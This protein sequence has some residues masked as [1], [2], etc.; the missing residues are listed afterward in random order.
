M[1]NRGRSG[2]RSALFAL[3]VLSA[4][5]AVAAADVGVPGVSAAAVVEP[6]NG[7]TIA[8]TDAPAASDDDAR[9]DM[10]VEVGIRNHVDPGEAMLVRVGVDASSLFDGQVRVRVSSVAPTTVDV[11]VPGG[12]TKTVLL[13]APGSVD[14][15][16]LVVELVE[17]GSIVE[18]ERVTIEGASD[19]EL[20]GVLPQLVARIGDLPETV[21]LDS[22]IGNA[23]LTPLDTAVL[24]LGP[25][26][27]DHLD[28]VVASGADLAALTD[29]ELAALTTW[30]GDGGRL[31]LDDDSGTGR[32]PESW[33]PGDAGY[34]IAGAG[35]VR[36]LD[37]AAGRGDFGAF[38]EP[39]PDESGGL[40]MVGNEMFVSPESEMASRAGVR[41]PELGPLLAGLVVYA[42]VVGPV[43]YLV[44]RRL[45]RLTAIWVVLPALAVLTTCGVALSGDRFR[46][47]GSPVTASFVQTS[48][49]GASALTNVLTF[50][51]TGGATTITSPDGWTLDTSSARVWG[52]FDESGT[53]GGVAAGGD[54]TRFGIDLQPGQVITRAFTGATATEDLTTTASIV[55]D[56]IV[57]TVT[58]DTPYTLRDVAVFA[59]EEAL[60][61]DDLAP[62]ASADWTADTPNRPNPFVSRA[63]RVW[64]N[65]DMGIGFTDSELAEFGIWSLGDPRFGLYPG[66]TVRV[67][68]WTDERPSDAAPDRSASDIAVITTLQ[69][70]AAGDEPLEAAAVRRDFVRSPFGRFGNGFG[71]IV[72]RYLLPPDADRSDLVLD[73]D[74]LS[75]AGGSELEV[76][77]GD[78]WVTL[79]LEDEGTH[80][81]PD[82]AADTG[83]V[84]VR[85]ASDPNFGIDVTLTPVVRSGEGER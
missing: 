18:S 16:Q 37:G 9:I 22:G 68:G 50:S 38:I 29:G 60:A 5:P 8:N 63:D 27:L 67:A 11:Q 71:P 46:S 26:A 69:P 4:G 1:R 28:S 59:G 2:R 58:N 80:P 52:M 31:L 85:L 57:G 14:V 47:T 66:G 61:I 74:D 81:L 83:A 32:L 56:Q 13:V 45:R 76:W 53:E 17:D 79:S 84:L 41:L 33:R 65:P 77:D 49:G 24:A 43:A 7:A 21:N 64:G 73:A 55:D 34:A 30:V 10:T 3:V 51:R 70:I 42:L 20:V 54:A 35:E 78:A 82:G 48:A 36:H 75:N 25:L 19:T 44:L 62:G 39:T 23:E 40:G 15:A 12:T 72:M 6:N